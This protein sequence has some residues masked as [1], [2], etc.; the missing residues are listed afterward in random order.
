[1]LTTTT[2]RLTAI[3]VL[4]AACT[5]ILI[6]LSVG[7]AHADGP[8]RAHVLYRNFCPTSPSEI[9]AAGPYRQ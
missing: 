6:A 8:A 1:M 5:A 7:S 4:A 2:R 9:V 3:T